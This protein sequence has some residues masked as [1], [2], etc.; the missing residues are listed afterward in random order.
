MWYKELE[1]VSHREYATG[2]YFDDPRENANLAS[3][4]GY[5]KDKAYLA[6]CISGS[7]D[8]KGAEFSQ[9]NK[10]S[11]GD[12]IELLTPGKVGRE[13]VC[14]NLFDERGNAVGSVPHPYMTFKMDLPF[15]VKVGDI[16]RAK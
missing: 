1:S 12:S 16:I 15:E 11:L 5:M 14:Q 9:R 8:G 10:M 4:N 2:Y 13:C 6:V 7:P 3:N